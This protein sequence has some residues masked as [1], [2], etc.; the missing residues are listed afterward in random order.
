MDSIIALHI[1]L[2]NDFCK[3]LMVSMEKGQTLPK[4]QSEVIGASVNMLDCF[5]TF[6]L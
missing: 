5:C 2:V 6:T 4:R 3:G 1:T